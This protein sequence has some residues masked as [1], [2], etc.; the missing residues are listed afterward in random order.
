MCSCSA[1]RAVPAKITARTN[2][3]VRV[4][5]HQLRKT[6]P[7]S[8]PVKRDTQ[9]PERQFHV[10]SAMNVRLSL[11]EIVSKPEIRAIAERRIGDTEGELCCPAATSPIRSPFSPVPD[12]AAWSHRLPLDMEWW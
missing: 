4:V 7:S 8:E 1:C 3:R 11:R 2:N 10:A 5:C 9:Q 6:G 12:P